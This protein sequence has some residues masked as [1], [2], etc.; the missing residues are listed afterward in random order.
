MALPEGFVSMI[1]SYGLPQFDN[2]PD[3]LESTTPEVSLRINPAKYTAP[4]PATDPVPWSGCGFYLPERPAFTL[5]PMLHQGAYYVQDASSMFISH[6][7]AHLAAGQPVRWLDACAAP[8]G[9]TTAVMAAL[10]QGS[11]VVANEFVRTR[12]EILREN[13]AKWGTANA[14]V[15]NCDTSRFSRHTALFDIIAADVPCSGE[16][17]MR[18]DPEAVA[19]W[20]PALINSC[21]D[22]Q[23]TIISNLWPAL[24]PG[25]YMVYSTCT[26]NRAENE[27]IIDW[28]I[29]EFGA[30]PVEI[31]AMPQWNITP[32]IA[33]TAPCYRFIPGTTRGEGL[34]LAVVRKPDGPIPN[35]RPAKAPKPAKP[36]KALAQLA[37]WLLPDAQVELSLDKDTVTATST[38][39]A[40]LTL[41]PEL[42]PATPIA[43]R[44]GR[45]FIPTQQLAL[46]TLLNP[47]IWPRLDV[48]R[49]TALSYLRAEA[50]HL[51]EDTPRG[52]VLLTYSGLPLGFVKNLGNRANNLYPD[53]WRIRTSIPANLP[54]LPLQ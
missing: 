9:K 16:G 20:S 30:L 29:D 6:V 28:M 42:R 2:L 36:D 53:P 47:E 39:P 43:T 24:R 40:A 54:P 37:L 31:P 32:G 22:R 49:L 19:Q 44:K 5:D 14:A 13:V 27:H 1:R 46:S 48:D 17:M 7:A 38:A 12:A 35:S 26:F 4:F 51:P 50:L 25:G 41:P 21:A 15:T 3:A 11:V 33:T 18:K 10:P 8:G 52:I 45:D 34:F 23:R